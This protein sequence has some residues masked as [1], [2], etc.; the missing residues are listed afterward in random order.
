MTR[1]RKLSTMLISAL[2]LSAIILTGGALGPN[3]PAAKAAAQSGASCNQA[4]KG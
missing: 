4:I 2:A 1:I 3:T